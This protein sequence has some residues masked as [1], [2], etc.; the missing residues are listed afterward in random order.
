M[1]EKGNYSRLGSTPGHGGVN[2]AIYSGSAEAVE[3]C[4]FDAD[5]RETVR[6]F[7]PG[8][9]NS[10]WHG[11]LP[12]CEAGQ[13]YGYRV[14]GPWSPE[15]GLRHNP[16]KL[17][18]DP[19]AH[20]L[21][22]AFQWNPSVFDFDPGSENGDWVINESDSAPYVPKS[23]I[24]TS[25]HGS[26]FNRPAVPWSSAVIYEA[27]VRGYTMRHP[28][29]PEDQRGRFL[30]MSNGQ[31]L[32]HL[33]AL[34]VTSLELMPVHT[35]IDEDFLNQKGLRNF[36]GYNNIQFFT[37]EARFG[38]KDPVAEFRE[39]VNTIH[40]AGIE[41]ILDV[42]YNHTGE[43]GADGP[44]LSL[45]GIDNQAYYRSVPGEPGR[46]VNDTGC[47]NTLNTDHIRAQNLVLDSLRYWHRDMGVDG[48]RFDLATILGRTR[49][50]FSKRHSLLDRIGSEPELEGAKLIAEPWDTGPG[51]YQLGRFPVEWA[52]WND[53]YRDSVRRFWRGD[54]DQDSEFARRIHGSADLFEASGRNPPASINFITA[55]DGYTLMDV[56]SYERRHNQ[57]NGEDNRDGH[58]HNFSC[59]HGVEGATDDPDIQRIRRQQRLNMLATLLLSQGTPMLL[60]GD[61]FGNSQAG[62]NN[63][64]AQD[65]KTGWLDWS[66][67]EEDPE[68]MWSVR[69]LVRLRNRLPLLR[70]ARYI[71][72][73]MPTDS[74]WCDITWLHPDARPM[75]PQDWNSSRQLALVFS[76]HEDQKDSSPVVE[77]VAILFNASD[78]DVEFALPYD[79]PPDLVMQFSSARQGS[80]KTG[81]GMWSVAARSLVLLSS[82]LDA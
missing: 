14:H 75:L 51:G 31:I 26:P 78:E 4:L 29:I 71:H 30:G 65:N 34:G 16:A 27:N 11:F 70:Q 20:R 6:H 43:G 28:D 35:M 19:Y 63:A 5:G 21:S 62:N 82:E 81:F 40:E 58:A 60:G 42:A 55:H 8:Q 41:V 24:E 3:L 77:A 73:R 39:M 18:I 72:G 67:L 66:G 15:K 37:P 64:Y 49:H 36:W 74:G 22:G 12:G 23:V 52:E 57:A 59:N 54:K 61:E 79:L 13:R 17:L 38:G 9:H 45:K 50:G 44:T 69:E 56:V 32:E 10:V 33:R 25:P 80:G 76:A 47:G 48:F 7:M 68:F 53:Q 2:F 46:Y 1:L